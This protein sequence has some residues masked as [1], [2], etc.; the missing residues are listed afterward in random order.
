MKKERYYLEKN[1]SKFLST[2]R[3]LLCILLKPY[4]NLTN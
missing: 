1:D 3:H 2:L 4:F